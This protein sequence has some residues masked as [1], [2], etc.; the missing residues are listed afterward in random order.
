MEIKIES[1]K[2]YWIG[3]TKNQLHDLDRLMSILQKGDLY[4]F[5]RQMGITGIEMES[6]NET[7]RDLKE[8]LQ[9]CQNQ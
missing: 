4:S 8:V 3:I 7:L 2:T 1:V 9:Q 5:S 6:I